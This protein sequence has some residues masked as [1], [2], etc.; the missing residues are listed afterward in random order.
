MIGPAYDG[1]Y[2]LIGFKKK[3]F[4]PQVFERMAWGTETVF[5]ETMK[6]LKGLRQKIHTLP[7]Q[8]DI[9]T[10]EDLKHLDI[11]ASLNLPS[12]K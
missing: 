7:Y 6:V 1:G 12:N 4:S 8:K 3:T 2:Y 9:D 11:G 5:N 10:I